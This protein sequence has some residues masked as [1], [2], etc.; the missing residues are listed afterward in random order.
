IDVLPLFADAIAREQ[1][2]GIVTFDEARIF[3]GKIE[4]VGHATMQRVEGLLLKCAE[5]FDRAARIRPALPTVQGAEERT[6]FLEA[7][8]R[9]V[10][11]HVILQTRAS[12]GHE[13]G[14]GPAE[15]ARA[16][17]VAEHRHRRH[18]LRIDRAWKE[19]D[20][21]RHGRVHPRHPGDAGVERTH[22]RAQRVNAEDGLDV[23]VAVARDERPHN[24]KLVREL[25]ELREGAAERNAGEGGFDF[26]GGA[27]DGRGRIHLW[28]ERLELR[29]PAVHEEEDDG[30]ILE[31]K[32][33]AG[34]GGPDGK[35]VTERE[36]AQRQTARAQELAAVPASRLTEVFL[37]SQH[38]GWS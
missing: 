8:L 4:G 6:S 19:G 37:K 25:G 14:N 32:L 26:A 13:R 15:L 36:P 5:A 38:R 3:A 11:A 21:R 10:Q 24:A 12:A 27:A 33:P 22:V 7:A 31:W 35:Q 1:R 17:E 18:R 2:R 30:T 28:I 23:V 9:Q 29:R 20:V 34:S 16:L